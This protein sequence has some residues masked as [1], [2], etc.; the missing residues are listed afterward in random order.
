MLGVIVGDSFPPDNPRT[1]FVFQDDGVQPLRGLL[2]EIPCHI[3]YVCEHE[4]A[5]VGQKKADPK[6]CPVKWK[7][8]RSTE[9]GDR[10]NGIERDPPWPT[11]LKH[12]QRSRKN[13][14]Q[15]K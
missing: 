4:G 7:G 12:D 3:R 9:R 2:V 15:S 10:R 6:R 14:D 11:S 5:H 1:H 13:P 8:K